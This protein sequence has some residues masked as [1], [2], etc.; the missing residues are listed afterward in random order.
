MFVA[1]RVRGLLLAPKKAGGGGV[2]MSGAG[3]AASSGKLQQD[4][5]FSVAAL[6]YVYEWN[7]PNDATKRAGDVADERRA[8]EA[9]DRYAHL[10]DQRFARRVERLTARMNAALEACPEA[11]LEEATLL[12]SEAPP[13][14]FRLPK[15]TPPVAGFD[16]AF[17]LDVPQLRIVPLED[18]PRARMTD[19]MQLD[20]ML[21]NETAR[22]DS[23]AS[24][25]TDGSGRNDDGGADSESLASVYPLVDAPDVR[26]LLRD[27]EGKLEELHGTMRATAPLTGTSGEEWEAHCALQRR[28][29]ARQRLILDV[30]EDADF[31]ARYAASTPADAEAE[32]ERRGIVALEVEA[33]PAGYDIETPEGRRVMPQPLADMHYAQ[34]PKYH[35]FRE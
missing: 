34:A 33:A 30:A 3:A 9:Y 29:F 5:K 20:A 10:L 13:P 7:P 18:V 22:L 31:A 23:I 25:P 21:A 28:A 19:R 11:L 26:A 17:G 16:P 2:G 32:R 14:A 12:N 1:R 15:L 24:S 4:E 35:P 8:A 27:A 6:E